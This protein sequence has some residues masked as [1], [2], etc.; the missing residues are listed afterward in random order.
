MKDYA[1]AV[2][3]LELALASDPNNLRYG[4]DYRKA[5]I[6]GKQFDRAVRFFEQLAARYPTSPNLHLNFGFAYVDKIPVAGSITQVILANNALSEFSKALELEHSWVGYYTRGVSF[7]F[8]PK[9]FKRAP[10]GVADLEAAMKMQKAE[11][12]HGYHLKTYIALGDGYWK[13][14]DLSKARAVWEE[15][16]KVFPGSAAL[17]RRISLSGDELKNL[18]EAQFDPNTRVNTDLSDLWTD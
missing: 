18:I 14:D 9:I 17:Q 2:D 4:N 16:L 5:I 3:H 8:W 13:V 1:G 10:L 7:L 11:R 12:R 15:G 6:A